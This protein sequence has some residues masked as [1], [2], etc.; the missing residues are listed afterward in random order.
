MPEIILGSWDASKD[1]QKNTNF[2]S[3]IYILVG[4]GFGGGFGRE[5][6]N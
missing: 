3:G 2:S 5:K 6:D 1:K 4:S